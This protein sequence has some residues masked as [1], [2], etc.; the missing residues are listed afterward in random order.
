MSARPTPQ[1]LLVVG[2]DAAGMSAASTAR[3]RKPVEE[4]EIV[5]FER[6][7]VTSYAACGLPY[8]VGDLFDDADELIARTPE[9][10]RANGI[11]VRTRHEVRAVDTEART[12]T[13]HDLDADASRTEPYDQ[14]VIATGA[15]PVR[16]DLPGVDAERV[17]GVQHFDEG[18]EL[19]QVVDE[20]EASRAVVVGGGYIGI[21]LGEALLRRG[22]DV[23][24]IEAGAAPMHALDPDM[25]GLVAD[26]MRE[27]GIDV[28]LNERVERFDVEDGTVRAVVTEDASY[29]ADLVVLGI[30][31][32]PNVDLARAAG[33]EI[34][35]TGGIRTDDHQRTS[36]DGVLAA[37]DCTE[38]R[39]RVTGDPVAI[40]L[41]TYANKQ[42]RVAGLNAT[43]GDAVF[44]GVLGTAVS[45]ICDVEVGRTGLTERQARDA[46]LDAF[47]TVVDATSRAGYFP[48]TQ[49]IKVRIVTERESGR[50]LGAQIIGKE[51]AAKRI[52]VFAAC[53]W[54]EMTVEEMISLDL[55][56]APPFAPLW[57]PVLVAARA[58]APQVDD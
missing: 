31:A 38:T 13:V 22:L 25:G 26:A 35:P 10:H 3:R 56:Y 36:A 48:D 33:I 47:A 5:A 41:G 40:A 1:R 19:R 52:D 14:L 49:P 50:L 32:R 28:R 7:G 54:N 37:G 4:L 16:P 51:G 29:D 45:R 27:L 11:D 17:F 42:G 2:G 55:G 58:A 20:G 43:G 46:G 21:E 6:S 15:R 23:T 8:L 57:D 34:G 30:G 12:L 53:L 24:L 39:M 44:P 18:V 9:E